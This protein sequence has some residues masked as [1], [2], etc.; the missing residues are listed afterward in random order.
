MPLKIQF[1]ILAIIICSIIWPLFVNGQREQSKSFPNGFHIGITGEG[2][3]AQ[4]MSIIPLS[5]TTPAPMAVPSL[6]WNAGMEF[7]GFKSQMQHQRL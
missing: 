4:R 2:N 1:R 7:A 6:G 5:G 3:V